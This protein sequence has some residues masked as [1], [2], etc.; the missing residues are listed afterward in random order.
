MSS[1]ISGSASGPSP[2]PPGPW[3]RSQ[4]FLKSVLPVSIAFGSPANGFFSSAAL[5]GSVQPPGRGGGSCRALTVKPAAKNRPAATKR[6]QRVRMANDTVF[7]V[8]DE[9]PLAYMDPVFLE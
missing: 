7:Q 4:C 6:L 8:S 1:W 3:Q 5:G 2:L 9:Q